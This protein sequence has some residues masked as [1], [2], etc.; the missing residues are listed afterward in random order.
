M[1]ESAALKAGELE[2]HAP[3]LPWSHNGVFSALDHT[4]IRRG[5]EVYKQV[6]SACHSMRFIAYRNLIGVSHT[7]AE[8]KREAEEIQVIIHFS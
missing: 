6:C 3:A 4:S 5:Y 8:A 7:E 1:L 2:C